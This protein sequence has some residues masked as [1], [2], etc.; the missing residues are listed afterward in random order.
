[1]KK[2]SF[3]ILF[4]GANILTFGANVYFLNDGPGYIY[5]NGQTFYSNQ[6]GHALVAYHV[7]AEPT[8]YSVSEWGARFQDPDGNW[9]SW[10]ALSSGQGLHECLKVGT[11]NVQGRVWVDIDY[12]T[13]Q[14]NFYMYT[15]FTLYF[16][17]VDN[18]APSA[19]QNISV[20]AYEAQGYY[21]PKL[22]WTLNSE[23]DV[24]LNSFGY[25]IDRRL[26]AEGNGNWTSWQTL[27]SVNGNSNY[28]IDYSITTAG[29]GP[30]KVQ[31]KLRAKD[32]YNNYSNYTS[33]VELNYGNSMN[34]IGTKNLNYSFS[35]SQNYPNPFNPT[36]K[37]KFN[38]P[39][40]AFVTLKV[41]DILGK[42]V[43]T[44]VNEEMS[45]ENHSVNF[46]ANNLPPGIYIYKISAGEFTEIKKMLLIK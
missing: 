37:I 16:Y 17:V 14:T 43:A 12:N 39:H 33:A 41:Y 18:Y 7:W 19:P 36:T 5:T 10:S 31:Y 22:T 11:W 3:L 2:L 21:S 24:T 20:Q 45:A 46:D 15:S 29:S 1:M 28:Y 23:I 4:F 32:V 44:L 30:S 35:L 27:D 42:K 13:Y 9:S 40:S 6:D 25:Y 38:I 8:R 26:D 34:K